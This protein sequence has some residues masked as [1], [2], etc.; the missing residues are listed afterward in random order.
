[1]SDCR[2][3]VLSNRKVALGLVSDHFHPAGDLTAVFDL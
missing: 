1:M 2:F 3:G